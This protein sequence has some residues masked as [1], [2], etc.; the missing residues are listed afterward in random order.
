MLVTKLST[1][2]QALREPIGCPL[3]SEMAGLNWKV[4]I[5]FDDPT[6]P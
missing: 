4:T 1:L 6:V 5:A 2:R 3:L